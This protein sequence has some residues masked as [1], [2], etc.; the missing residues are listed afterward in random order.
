VSPARVF[1]RG[2]VPAPSRRLGRVPPLRR[3][4]P[5]ITVARHRPSCRQRAAVRLPELV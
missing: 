3:S 2:T 4:Q 5:R 1:V